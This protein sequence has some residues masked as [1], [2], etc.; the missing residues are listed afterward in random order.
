MK[1]VIGAL[2]AVGL[3]IGIVAVATMHPV[4]QTTFLT[5][6]PIAVVLPDG[7]VPDRSEVLKVSTRCGSLVRPGWDASVGIPDRMF[8][9]GACSDRRHHSLWLVSWLGLALA[10][11]VLGLLLF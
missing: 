2:V 6:T 4:V 10:V 11:G 5:G 7:S 3:I 1:N 9:E 8:A